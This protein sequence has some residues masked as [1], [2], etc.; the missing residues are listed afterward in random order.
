MKLSVPQG[1]LDAILTSWIRYLRLRLG[2]NAKSM[3]RLYQ[4]NPKLVKISSDYL[5]IY[6]VGSIPMYIGG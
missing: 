3:L 5:L 4:I 6:V 1:L 2:L